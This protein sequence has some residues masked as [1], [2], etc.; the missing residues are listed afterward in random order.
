V[1]PLSSQLQVPE[2]KDEKKRLQQIT[3]L[4]TATTTATTTISTA[5]EL[6]KSSISSSLMFSTPIVD[7]KKPKKWVPILFYMQKKI[8]VSCTNNTNV[9]IFRFIYEGLKNMLL[10]TTRGSPPRMWLQKRNT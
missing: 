7:N 1:L 2:T 5:K 8:V 10:S 4:T 3:Y 9:W 6:K